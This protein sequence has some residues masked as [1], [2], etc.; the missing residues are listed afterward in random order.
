MAANVYS[1]V[2]R[3]QNIVQKIKRGKCSY[4]FIEVMACPSGVLVKTSL[5][6]C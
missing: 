4:H 5:V 2:F 3:L 1:L 6:L